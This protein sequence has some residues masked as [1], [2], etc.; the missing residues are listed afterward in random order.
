MFHL[1]PL[2][3]DKRQ[4]EI[5]VK[6]YNLVYAAAN[7]FAYKKTD[8]L[9]FDEYVSAGIEALITAC[10]TYRDDLSKSITYTYRLIKNAMINKK[11]EI[12]RH[13]IPMQDG[14]DMSR[15]DGRVFEMQSSESAEIVRKRIMK[16]VKGNER[17]AEVAEMCIIEELSLK[18][19]AEIFHLSHESV[20]L[21]YNKTLAALQEDKVI[22]LTLGQPKKRK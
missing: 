1:K 15:Y 20:R 2:K 12:V 17:N 5:L 22:R 11:A 18:E 7:K 4:E 13:N 3:M 10:E 21:I 9:A 16:A 8:S 6:H 14:Y 19:V